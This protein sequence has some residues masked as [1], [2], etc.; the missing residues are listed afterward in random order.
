MF[1][2]EKAH[3][4][5]RGTY[6][7]VEIDDFRIHVCHKPIRPQISVMAGVAIQYHGGVVKILPSGVYKNG[8]VVQ[9]GNT[10]TFP[11]GEVVR[12]SHHRLTVSVPQSRYA[13]VVMG[14][15][16][17]YRDDGA[18]GILDGVTEV[19]TPA[20]GQPFRWGGPFQGLY[21][22]QYAEGQKVSP[23]EA[24]FSSAEC[25]Y[26]DAEP[27]SADPECPELEPQAQVQC[28]AGPLHGD[29]VGDVVAMCDLTYIDK[30]REASADLQ[31]VEEPGVPC[32]G[33]DAG[34]SAWDN[35]RGHAA[36]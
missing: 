9:V 31:E 23:G 10:F 29:C 5:G 18:G 28:P 12:G 36:Q 1:S 2:D 20:S 13:E 34:A 14:L 32:R 4:M 3:P 7:L 27:E 15:C 11:G 22:S 8:S 24:L 17:E 21:Q 19:Y 35:Q 30:A 16:G 33:V 25:P 26:E 6:R